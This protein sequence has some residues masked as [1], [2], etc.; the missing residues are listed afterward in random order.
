MTVNDTMRDR[1]AT[2]TTELL[3]DRPDLA[4]VLADIGVSKFAA[5][6]ALARHPDRVINVGIREQLMVSFAAGMALEGFRPILHSYTP[7]LVERPYEQIKLDL[8]HQDLGAILVSIGAS[9]DASGEGRTHQAPADVAVLSALPGW[10]IHVPGHPDEVETL[11]RDAVDG[12]GRVYLRLSEQV[13]VHAVRVTPGRF[14]LI[15]RGSQ[16]APLTIA[17]GPLL[18]NVLDA[19]RHLDMTVLYA[20]TI[21][22]FDAAAVLAGLGGPEVI[23]VE[24]YLAGTSSAEVSAALRFVPHRLLALGVPAAEHRHYGSPREH[25]AAHGLDARGIAASIEAFL[26]PVAA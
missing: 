15:R 26:S 24:P 1:F 16:T 11:L 5:T 19:T 6:G 7:F 22:P 12:D 9:Y 13:N 25:E 2:V 10:Q 4:V 8:G 20:A 3:D 14:S 17:V 18:D 23:L 21:R